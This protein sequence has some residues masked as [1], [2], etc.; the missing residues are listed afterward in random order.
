MRK[1]NISAQVGEML[2][3][4][5]LIHV[6]STQDWHRI[7]RTSKM[8]FGWLPVGH[9]WRHH[10]ADNDLCPCCGTLD[11]ELTELRERSF[12]Q[13]KLTAI[14]ARIPRAVYSLA[15][16][17][18]QSVC[19]CTDAI[20]IN[21]PFPLQQVMNDQLQVGLHNFAIGWFVKYGHQQCKSTAQEILVAKLPNF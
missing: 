14:S 7:V 9:N 11:P 15:E 18:W 8:L 4:K 2:E 10:C 20:D 19:K 1:L 16:A 5:H 6:R 3:D 21:A 17:M 13:M 12:R